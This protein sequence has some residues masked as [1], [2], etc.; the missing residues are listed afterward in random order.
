M[1]NKIG[2]SQIR[3]RRLVWW[4]I[5]IFT[6]DKK[7][8]SA[9]SVAVDGDGLF[10]TRPVVWAV[11]WFHFRVRLTIIFFRYVLF[12]QCQNFR[13][14]IVMREKKIR[15]RKSKWRKKNEEKPTLLSNLLFLSEKAFTEKQASHPSSHWKYTNHCYGKIVDEA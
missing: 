1:R 2:C 4:E 15:R 11:C 7:N 8:I 13:N 3:N 12:V 9:K 6:T 10:F 5:F 14:F